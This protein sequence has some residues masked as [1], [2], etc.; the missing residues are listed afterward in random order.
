MGKVRLKF[1][2]SKQG[3]LGLFVF[4]QNSLTCSVWYID[5]VTSVL[6]ATASQAD[7]GHDWGNF[8]K[9]LL[10]CTL[11]IYLIL[12]IIQRAD[13]SVLYNLTLKYL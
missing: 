5:A 12:S 2:P 1:N 13:F 11:A 3:F 7:D 4:C 10:L 8:G 6:M 9:R